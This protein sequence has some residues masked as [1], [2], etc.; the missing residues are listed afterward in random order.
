MAGKESI[1]F[2]KLYK[3]MEGAYRNA[4][5]NAKTPVEVETVFIH[6]ATRILSEAC[7]NVE[8]KDMEYISFLPENE[9]PF[10]FEKRFKEKIIPDLEKSDLESIIT[11]LAESSKN[12]YIKI[13]HD[14]D[15]TDMFR[16]Q[17]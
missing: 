1:S 14:Q 8:G 7:E 5:N 4:L 10:T 2:I 15:R 9:P 13:I 11:K 16:R 17:E 6:F 3:E 12:R